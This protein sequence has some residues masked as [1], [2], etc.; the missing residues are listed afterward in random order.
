MNKQDAKENYFREQDS[1]MKWPLFKI[2]DKFKDM[3]SIKMIGA[4]K[5]YHVS[6]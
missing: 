6:S 3:L 5:C 1:L 4:S 2:E